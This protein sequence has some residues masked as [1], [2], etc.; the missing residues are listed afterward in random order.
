[1][2]FARRVTRPAFDPVDVDRVLFIQTLLRERVIR[3]AI[4]QARSARGCSVAIR[5]GTTDDDPTA[6]SEPGHRSA[7]SQTPVVTTASYPRLSGLPVSW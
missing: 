1:M 5:A 6:R 4:D 2:L 7:A 3:V